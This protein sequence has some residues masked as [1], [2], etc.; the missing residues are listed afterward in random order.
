MAYEN[1]KEGN[2]KGGGMPEFQNE[3]WQKKVPDVM[4]A[5]GKYSS[6]MNQEEEYRASVNKLAAYTKS[7]KPKY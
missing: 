7:H 6:E 5:D 4:C 2:K 3:H 1:N